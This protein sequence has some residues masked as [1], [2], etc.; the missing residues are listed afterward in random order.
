MISRIFVDRPIF[1][2]V[3]SIVIMLGG[4][5]AVMFLPIEQYPDI[6]PPSVNIRAAYPGA[7]AETLE[8]SVT[9]VIEQQLT[10][11]DGLLYFTSASSSQGSTTITATFEKGTDPDIAQ[12]Q[13][14]NKVQ[15]AIARLP[16]QVQ[17]QGLS[18]TKSNPDFL[19]IAAVY[20]TTDESS[21]SDV[22][23][24]LVANL[25]DPIGRL[26]GVGDLRVFGSPYAMRIW[27]DPHR[28][29]GYG[30]MPADVR[31]AILAQ[32]VQVAAGQLGAQPSPSEQMLNATVTAK[33]RLETPEQFRNILLKS[34]P[35]GSKVLLSDVA[36]VELG[37]DDYSTVTRVNRHPGSGMAIM[38]APG[39]DA[40]ETAELVKAEVERRAQS[41]PTGYEY[42][43]P[44]DSTAFIRLSIEE[45]VKTLLEAILLVVVVM[46]VFLQSWR[47]TLIPTI[48]VPVVLLGTFGVL[49]L[50][51]FSINTLT[52]FGLVLAIGLLVDDA[53][54]VVEN[55]ERLM[56]ENP[57]M[58]PRQATLRSMGEIQTAL[59]AI[60][61][62][63]SA[64]F[65]PMAFFGGSTGVIYRQF[66]ITIVSSM[67]LSVVVALVLTPALCA[68]LLHRPGERPAPRTGFG[69]LGARLRDGFNARF[70]RSITA[71]RHAV[72]R[73][74]A[75][76][77]L[78]MLFYA[79]V[80]ALLVFVFLRLP[81]SF[82]PTEDEGSAI[83]QYTLPSGATQ[84]RS[85]KVAQQV[86]D[87]FLNNEQKNVSTLFT[88]TGFGFGGSGQNAG[89]GF[90]S[91]SPWDQRPGDENAV[92]SITQRASRA[93][94]QV[95]DAQVFALT[96][97]PVRGLGQSSGFTL[98]L[99]NSGNLSH[100][101]F[102]ARRDQLLA[103][104]R[105]DPL[106][107]AV[108][109]S[110]LEDTP[111]LHVDIDEAKVGALGISQDDVYATLSAAWG[112]IYVNDFV[113]R[114][115]VKRVY[116]QGDAAYRS[117]PTDLDHWFVRSSNGEMAPFSSFAQTTWT[118]A[119]AVLTRFSGLPS[120]EIQGQAAPGR[121]SGDAMDRIAEL[122]AK[123]QGTSIAWAGLS[124]QERLAGG[125]A[126]LLYALSLLVVFLCLAALY[127]SWSVPIGVLLVIPIGLL[128]AVL[129]V[130]AR[131][132]Q[133][134]VFFQVGLLTTMGLSA[135]NAILIVE[136]AEHAEREGKSPYEAALEAAKLRLR[137]ILM[138]SFAFI[139]GVL[140][141]A[142]STG[143]GARSRVEIGTTVLGGMLAAT[144]LAI[145]YVPMF[146]VLLRR[147]FRRRVRPEEAW[148]GEVAPDQAGMSH[149][150]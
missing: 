128:G 18:V 148:V 88:I 74:I 48:A 138:T 125:Q 89:L 109:P 130:F 71:Y 7:S 9:Q 110:G 57:G 45:V 132:L 83:V 37:S 106:L 62:V 97:P 52:L 19:L 129:A 61:L 75:R 33:S 149:A 63:L 14:Q 28:L 40:L 116:L 115:R 131:G 146:F 117:S 121:S 103:E 140:P 99:L 84:G 25:Q 44:R 126:P 49:A 12:V 27:L 31:A 17:Q 112:S 100:D 56:D 133:N 3:I 6:A 34:Q 16:Q 124:Y 22:A 78:F 1:A 15:Q 26:P 80:C 143:A 8:T 58:G 86:E 50:F 122:S 24:Y 142:L 36:R 13:V 127:E 68:S 73:V 91:L 98:E 51:G 82:L 136:F 108:R 54:V 120:Y 38:L 76:T 46:F 4:A 85:L 105:S 94:S 101:E 145:F 39:S 90:M 137:P 43:F 87:Y 2:W 60:A 53:I 81:T 64:V 30:L 144:A 5:G 11:I 69:R 111:T 102:K 47:A 104:A 114:G 35:D 23:D 67:L 42:S 72:S 21:N 59:I 123:L 95:R 55:V 70:E 29:A 107:A 32:N 92:L 65:L 113:D 135:K 41:F 150:E 96:P 10:G 77:G 147:L 119:P 139:F 79:A 66:S 93:L 134:D 118:N 20:D 141:L